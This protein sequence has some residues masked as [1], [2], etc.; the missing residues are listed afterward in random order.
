L[1]EPTGPP[2]PIRNGPFIFLLMPVLFSDQVP[3]Y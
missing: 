1:P 2:M 3:R